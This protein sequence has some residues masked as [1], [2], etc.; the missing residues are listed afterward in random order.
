MTIRNNGDDIRILLDSWSTTL[1]TWG[2]I[3]EVLG[4]GQRVKPRDV[5][6]GFRA[7]S[8]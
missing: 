2:V 5:N 7:G 6:F 4:F 1:T 8:F 3:Y